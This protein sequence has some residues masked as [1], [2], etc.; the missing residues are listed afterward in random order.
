MF[1]KKVL[2]LA[3]GAA[4]LAGAQ[5]SF[6]GTDSATANYEITLT[7]PCT[8][9]ASG[10]V[11][12][13]QPSS[14]MTVLD[15]AAGIVDV[16]CPVGVSYDW[17]IDKGA[18][19]STLIP[20]K[21]HMNGPTGENI[22]YVLTYAGLLIGDNG[23]QNTDPSYVPTTGSVMSLAFSGGVMQTGSGAAQSFDLRAQVELN[24]KGSPYDAGT[25]T[26]TVRVVVAF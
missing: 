17:G 21:R 22:P 8:I 19:W 20:E 12:P 26:D 2:A 9:T 4:L 7:A 24:A 6:A 10:Q 14:I 11:F 23:L 13:G 18:H 3:T 5:S 15:V 25:Y 16:T 1:N